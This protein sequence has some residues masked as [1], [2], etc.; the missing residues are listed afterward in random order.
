[1]EFFHLLHC[2]VSDN[3]NRRISVNTKKL[4]ILFAILSLSYVFPFPSSSASLKE[5]YENNHSPIYTCT[6]IELKKEY[7]TI[8]CDN[9]NNTV[10]LPNSIIVEIF[11]Y[12]ASED[13]NMENTYFE[14]N[15]LGFQNDLIKIDC[16]RRNRHLFEKRRTKTFTGPFKN[17]IKKQ[18]IFE[19]KKFRIKL[20]ET[21]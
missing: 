21:T 2:Y 20:N 8:Q 9:F 3:M 19:G 7:L 4:L 18:K 14:C 16:G 12:Y 10:D 1:M 17:P 11:L 13:F 15:V 5:K 6:S